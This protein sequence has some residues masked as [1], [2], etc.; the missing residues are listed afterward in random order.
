MA[1]MTDFYK[2]V[3]PG[4]ATTTVNDNQLSDNGGAT[5]NNYSWYAR[6]IQGSGARLARYAEYNSMDNDVEIARALDII[7]EE[8]TAKNTKTKLPLD[9]D[10]L[11]EDGQQVDDTLVLTLRTALRHW[12]KI[13]EFDENRLFK[14]ARNMVKYGDCFFRKSS[15]YKKWQWIPSSAVVAAIVA[16]DDITK[17]IGYQ[18]RT[19]TKEPM[20]GGLSANNSYLKN[21]STKGKVENVPIEQLVVFSINDDMSDTAPFGESVL[22]TVYKSHKQKELIEDAVIIYR[23]QR[24]PE[25]RVFYIDVGKMPPH[26]IKTYLETIRNELKQKKIPALNQNGEA[27]IDAVYDPHC[28]ALDTKIPLLD[29]RVLE[30]SEIIS[31]WGSGKELW[32]HSVNPESGEFVPGII[33][34]AGITRKNTKVIKITFDNDNEL[35]CTPDH[36]F[37]TQNRGKVEAKDLLVEDSLF[38]F[39]MEVNIESIE[40]LDECI[41]TGTLTIDGQEIHHNYH[42]FAIDAGV[43][44]YNSTNQDIYLAQRCLSLDTKLEIVGVGPIT[45]FEV[46][47]RQTKGIKQSVITVDQDTGERKICEIGWAD[48]TRRDTEIVRIVFNNRMYL[49]CTPDHKVIMDDLSE[50]MANDLKHGDKIKSDGLYPIEVEKVVSNGISNTGCITV[51]T[52]DNNHN[53][54][55]SSGIFVRNSDGVGSKVEV[56]PGGCFAMDTKVSL[57]DG[58]ELSIR[59]I[60]IELAEGKELWTYSC[61]PMTGKIVPGLISWA[62]VT[63]K[64]AKVMKITLDNGEEVICTP[65]HKFPVYEKE[66]KRAHE[67]N[68]GDSFIPL[69]RKKEVVTGSNRLDYEQVFDNSDKTWKY[70]HR[71]VAD[72][73]KDT[74]VKYHVYNPDISNG[75]YE[76]RHHINFNRFDNSP[77]NLCFMSWDDHLMYHAMSVSERRR[78][79]RENRPEEFQEYVELIRTKVKLHWD[80]MT[81]EDRDAYSEKH[82]MLWDSLSDSQRDEHIRKVSEGVR[83]YYDNRSD[84]DRIAHSIRSINIHANMPEE[85][86]ILSADKISKGVSKYCRNLSDEDRAAR[87]ERSIAA[88]KVG[89][90]RFNYLMD[91]D[92]EFRENVVGKRKLYWTDDTKKHHSEKML[93]AKAAL[94]NNPE[95]KEQLLQKHRDAQKVVFSHNMLKYI[96]SLVKGKTTHQVTARD[97]T[98]ALNENEQLVNEL[99]EL[100]KHKSVPQWNVDNKFTLTLVRDQLVKQFGYTNWNDFRVKES[101]HNHTVVNIEYLD[102]EIDVGTLTIDQ[103]E[104]HHNY[105]NFALSCGILVCNSNLG[106]IVELDHF[107]N[108]VLRGLRIPLQWMGAQGT[109]D[110]AIFND[111]KLGAAYVEEQQFA[112]FVERM[113]FYVHSVLDKEFKQFIRA[114][115]I[116]V[117]HSL[118]RVMLPVPSNYEHYKQTELDNALLST[119]STAD[120]VPWLS[121]RF[122]ARRYLQLSE[123]EILTNE[124]LVKEERGMVLNADKNLKSVYGQPEEPGMGDMG[125]GDMGMPSSIGGPGGDMGIPPESP[126]AGAPPEIP[127]GSPAPIAP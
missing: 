115:N 109:K 58:R 70:T 120:N 4:I 55:L 85:V 71:M 98:S 88:R 79:L 56:L 75:K 84:S 86:K 3:S 17:V 119:I 111:G 11:I 30:L 49:D 36:K 37:P 91:N 12:A 10:M 95:T 97:V 105:H 89:S 21:I 27:S 123:D 47:S 18:I 96:I 100:N 22:R 13:H 83:R 48:V 9:L 38:P 32:A 25:R 53:F 67:F 43:Y 16:E 34:W 45:L 31:E 106:E 112:K 64:S 23:I 63:H 121:K 60:E 40:N 24:A 122:I 50:V 127:A 116:N 46:I 117:D 8:M 73:L 62:G 51:N 41:D 125:M 82:R 5:T 72:Y 99:I 90:A 80:S 68:I 69:Y 87:R 39:D 110:G 113:Q 103:D 102:E 78:D 65:D 28:L 6:L 107:S 33:T 104:I 2:V 118:F 101:L 44:I 20:H 94:L 92:P 29:G 57:L 93:E 74:V 42:T 76:V 108:K 77:T 15:H 114:C 26:R 61:E 81:A 7:A 1:K 54:L 52:C 59:E 126:A 124:K 14:V 66:F 19:D 35:I